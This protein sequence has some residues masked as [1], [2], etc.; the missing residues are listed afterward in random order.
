MWRPMIQEAE[1]GS[2]VVFPGWLARLFKLAADLSVA[3]WL[4]VRYTLPPLQW[5]SR[6][7]CHVLPPVSQQTFAK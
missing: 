7:V 6:R 5:V 2:R 4:D 1:G 3:G